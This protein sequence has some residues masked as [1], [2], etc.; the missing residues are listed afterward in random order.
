M[1]VG[2]LSDI[3]N[4]LSIGASD[5]RGGWEIRF[6]VMN[7]TDAIAINQRMLVQWS[8]LMGYD[9]LYGFKEREWTAFD[10]HVM[11]FRFSFDVAGSVITAVAQTTDGFL[12]RGWCQG[13]GFVDTGAVARAHYHQFDSVTG[14]PIERMTLGRIVRHLLG[15]Y[16]TLG[17]PPPSNPDWVAHTNLVYHAVQNPHGW[18]TLAH[19]TTAPFADPG[20]LDGSMRTDRYIVRESKNLWQTLRGIASNEFFICYFDKTNTF[21]YERHPMY[22]A[23]PATSVTTLT[24][25]MCSGKPVV[26]NRYRDQ[27]RQA[28]LHAVDDD[29]DTLHAEYPASPAW[30]YGNIWE[31]SYIRCNSQNALDHWAEVYYR[32]TNRPYQVQWTMPGL[33][34]LLFDV[35]D[36]VNITYQGTDQNGVHLNWLN[37]KF[38]ISNI[39]VY[40]KPGHTGQSVLT[41]EADNGISPP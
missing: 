41:L 2:E 36:P 22:A 15:Y 29:G 19:V 27:I 23:T 11:P 8:P 40:P 4:I 3:S 16:D 34:G 20:N 18:I 7:D 9:F 21:H 25:R 28:L 35:M 30:V 13:I 10:G 33:A 31:Q 26:I 39:M 12:R 5:S 6:R 38:W 17:A 37:E 1:I 24:A 14:V 32:Y